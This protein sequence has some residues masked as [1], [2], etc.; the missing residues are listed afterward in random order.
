LG[1]GLGE[2]RLIDFQ[3]VSE[4]PP[5]PSWSDNV[6]RPDLVVD[7][8]D[9]PRNGLMHRSKQCLFDHL[10]GAGEYQRSVVS[11]LRNPYFISGDAVPTGMGG[12][13][14]SLVRGGGSTPTTGRGWMSAGATGLDWTTGGD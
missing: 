7:S 5:K 1:K 9:L 4:T 2:N 11:Q 3:D 14:I 10:V 8:G 13:G 6:E 12:R